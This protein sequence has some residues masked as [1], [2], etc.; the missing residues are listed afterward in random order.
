VRGGDGSAGGGGRRRG[1]MLFVGS[2][3]W[4][5][6]RTGV[7]SCDPRVRFPGSVGP[8]RKPGPSRKSAKATGQL[9]EQA[10]HAPIY[11]LPSP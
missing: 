10:A 2:P 6:G 11:P 4:R 8:R 7:G 1:G 3:W 9:R 5:A